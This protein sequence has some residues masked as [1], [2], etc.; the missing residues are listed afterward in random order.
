MYFLIQKRYHLNKNY[1]QRGFTVPCCV[2]GKREKRLTYQRHWQVN[3][4]LLCMHNE[5][6]TVPWHRA[7]MKDMLLWHPS[8]EFFSSF[9]LPLS[10]LSK[11]AVMFPGSCLL[12]QAI[13]HNIERTW[14]LVYWVSELVCWFGN[15]YIACAWTYISDAGLCIFTEQTFSCLKN[16]MNLLYKTRQQD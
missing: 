14:S 8:R 11:E 10:L 15:I 3:S 7:I 4:N 16:Y 12:F 1:R 2:D 5:H 9:F 6:Y 13:S